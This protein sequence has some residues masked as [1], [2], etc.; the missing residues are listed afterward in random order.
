[1]SNKTVSSTAHTVLYRDGET[2]YVHAAEVWSADK[3]D[4]VAKSIHNADRGTDGPY[5]GCV[6]SSGS[7]YPGYGQEQKYNG[8]CVRDGEWYNGEIIP[9]P[10]IPASYEFYVIPTWGTYIRKK[11]KKTNS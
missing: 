2:Y 10:K 11:P 8:G 3:C 6:A 9:L 4:K 7:G 1:M 5:R